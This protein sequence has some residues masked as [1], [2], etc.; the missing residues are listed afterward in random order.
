MGE[1]GGISS[2]SASKTMNSITKQVVKHGMGRVGVAQ[3]GRQTSENAPKV[4]QTH[5]RTHQSR[6]KVWLFELHI[7]WHIF[8]DVEP[9][10][11]MRMRYCST[12]WQ[13]SWRIWHTSSKDA[14]NSPQPAEANSEITELW[15]RS[16]I[17]ELASAGWGLVDHEA[18]QCHFWSCCRWLQQDQQWSTIWSQAVSL[19]ILLPLVAARPTMVCASTKK[20][21]VIP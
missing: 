16:V 7:I 20:G 8:L 13:S 15:K 2:Q 18:G 1:G 12:C 5:L 3:I 11:Q 21:M 4:L 10:D 6:K 19:L 17:F 9:F 14:L